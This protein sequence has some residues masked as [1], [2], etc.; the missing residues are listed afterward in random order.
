MD[1]KELLGEELYEQVQ[2]K[3]DD[4]TKLIINDGSYIPREKLNEHNDKIDALENELKERD[5]QIDQLKN[6]TQ[7]SEEL[8]QKIEELQEKNQQTR[9]ELETQLQTQRLEAEIEKTL[10]TNKARNP[11]AVKA[12]LDLDS[13]ELTDDGVEGLDDQ[14]KNLQE[15]E[16][17]LFETQNSQGGADGFTGSDD[18]PITEAQLDNMTEDEINERWEDVSKLLKNTKK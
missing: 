3:L 2:A 4:D 17:Y 1:L 11:K 7:A 10:L 15:N 18:L 16:S 12:L 13:V 14:L 8:Q 5:Q 9:E 6:D